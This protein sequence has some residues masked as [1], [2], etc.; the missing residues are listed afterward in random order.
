[1]TAVP[2][3][4][5]G[6]PIPLP[7]PVAV[8][9]AVTRAQTRPALV[10]VVEVA[11]TPAVIPHKRRLPTEPI[12]GESTAIA[13]DRAH[14]IDCNHGRHVWVDLPEHLGAPVCRHCPVRAN[15]AERIR[16]ARRARIAR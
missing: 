11:P 13:R 15:Q 2:L 6:A 16:D 3:R 5:T 7:S 9:A 12:A 8:A 14:W 10:A 4:A 1:M